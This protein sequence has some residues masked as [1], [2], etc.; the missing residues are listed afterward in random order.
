MAS[1]A[2]LASIHQDSSMQLDLHANG[3]A[4]NN[5]CLLVCWS[6]V[7]GS[8]KTQDICRLLQSEALMPDE[9][10][11][12]F[13]HSSGPERGV[14][15]MKE[16]PAVRMNEELGGLLTWKLAGEDLIR[17]SGLAYAIVRPAALTE[18]PA[19]ADLEIAQGDN[20]KGKISRQALD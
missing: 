13:W 8:D 20:I 1:M 15:N 10:H 7:L 17:Q 6:R 2:L 5:L 19:G 12:A 11:L 14:L 18:E 3:I 4:E 9:L 16:P